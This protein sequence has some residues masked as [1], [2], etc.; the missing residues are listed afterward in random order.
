MGADSIG[1]K[2]MAGLLT[3]QAAGDLVKA[4]KSAVSLPIHVH[5]HATSGFASIALMKAS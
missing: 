3:P 2:D 5:S 4:L 1:I